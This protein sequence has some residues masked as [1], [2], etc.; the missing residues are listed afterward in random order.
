MMGNCAGP[1]EDH[2]RK[3]IPVLKVGPAGCRFNSFNLN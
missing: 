1:M 2:I 3:D